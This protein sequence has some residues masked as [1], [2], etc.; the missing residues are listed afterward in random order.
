MFEL[1]VLYVSG[2]R[3]AAAAPV[4]SLVSGS[5]VPLL[6]IVPCRSLGDEKRSTN[7]EKEGEEAPA[8]GGEKPANHAVVLK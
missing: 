8:Y 1:R 7:D 3:H 6:D 2:G 4:E 5:P